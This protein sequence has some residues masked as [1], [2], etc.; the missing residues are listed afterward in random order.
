MPRIFDDKIK[1]PDIVL[2]SC[3]TP[4]S[5]LFIRVL[6]TSNH[7]DEY[8]RQQLSFKPS[9]ANVTYT[10]RPDVEP[11]DFLKCLETIVVPRTD[12]SPV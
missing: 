4:R 2:V 6:Y 11:P 1:I 8:Q 3:I 9:S 5:L 7:V 10:C 12:E